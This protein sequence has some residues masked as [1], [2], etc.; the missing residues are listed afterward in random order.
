MMKK[1]KSY[2]PG[3]LLFFT[4]TILALSFQNCAPQK[5]FETS[6]IQKNLACDNGLCIESSSESRSSRDPA[7]EIE[8]PFVAPPKADLSQL[9]NIVAGSKADCEASVATHYKKQVT[10]TI[11]GGCGISCGKPSSSCQSANPQHYGICITE[12]ELAAAPTVSP[13][14]GGSG[15]T[16]PPPPSTL[17]YNFAAGD[18]ATCEKSITERLGVKSI[19]C[20]VGGG[21]GI[22]CGKASST[23]ES[24]NPDV[25][26][27]CVNQED[28]AQAK[29]ADA[30]D[31]MPTQLYN[32]VAGDRAT[33]ESTIRN[34]LKV[35]I[36][37]NV[38]AGC[39]ISCGKP[40]ETCNSANPNAYGNCFSKVDIEAV[41]KAATMQH[42]NFVAGDKTTCEASIKSRLGIR[43]ACTIG[44]G[45]GV[46]CGMPGPLCNSANPSVYGACIPK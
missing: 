33:C 43:A 10:C 13:S 8:S 17:M 40:G 31:L 25:F 26:G 19:K 5:G 4:A 24:A 9:Y 46:A 23:C 37:C 41:K 28:I 2:L 34:N 32:V 3:F 39:G 12:N 7:N 30:A 20:R 22:S 11:G 35:D 27:A 36:S 14:S 29:L 44:G 16:T 21:C 18:K 1:I 45:C 42:F 15:S 38:G 6:S